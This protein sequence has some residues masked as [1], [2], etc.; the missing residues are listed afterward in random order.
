M[1]AGIK[2]DGYGLGVSVS[3]FNNDGWPDIYVA[4]DFISNDESL[5]EQSQRHIYQLYQ[6]VNATPKLFQHGS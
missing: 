2:E 3:D 1:Q 6:Q 5:A 4:N